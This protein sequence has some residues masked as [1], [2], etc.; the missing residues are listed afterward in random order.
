[1]DGKKTELGISLYPDFYS[2]EELKEK[3]DFAKSL[4]Y[5]RIF[6][7][8]QLGDLGFEN[9]SDE[10]DDKFMFLFQYAKDNHMLCHVDINDTMLYKLGA[11]IHN[12]KPI[13]DMNIPIIR[14]DGGFSYDE[15]AI[16]T[17]NP[18]G[19]MIEENLSSLCEIKDRIQVVQEK[20]NIK[21]YCGCHNFFP[22]NDTGLSLDNALKAAQLFQDYH[23]ASGIFIGSLY[24]KNDLN[25]Q[26]QSVPTIEDHRYLPSHIQVKELLEY[27]LFDYI[28]FGDSDP[29]KD[30]LIEVSQSCQYVQDVIKPWQKE[31]LHPTEMELMKNM[32]VIEI[33]V[34]WNIEDEEV[35]QKLEDIVFVSRQDAAEYVIRGTQSREIISLDPDLI[36]KRTQYSI[37]IDNCL[38]NRYSGELQIMLDDLPPAHNVNVVGMVR[39]YAIRLLKQI[40]TGQLAFQLKGRR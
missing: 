36:I 23:C 27:E 1:M 4:G 7:S 24:S 35:I 16:L 22:R 38:S 5:K 31:M 37:T 26:G 17:N 14:L 11:D 39:P 9:T 3:L 8:I 40:H 6:T 28:I 33:P 13:Y 29:R 15:I 18:Y 25:A 19:I 34:Y 20:G 10:I 32:R 30:E 2:I 12:L 21:N